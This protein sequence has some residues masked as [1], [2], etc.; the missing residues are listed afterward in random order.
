MV[1]SDSINQNNDEELLKNSVKIGKTTMNIDK[2][3]LEALKQE[4]NQ[5]PVIKVLNF[6]KNSSDSESIGAIT[7]E[8]TLKL[9]N[10]E[11][12]FIQSNLQIQDCYYD[13]FVN[14]S[15]FIIDK[16]N[17]VNKLTDIK[18]KELDRLY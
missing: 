10:L 5:N 4:Y 15:Q 8:F 11:L 2:D 14:D 16:L 3:T 9:G 6:Q 12:Q 18:I 13:P 7:V 1:Q 17:K